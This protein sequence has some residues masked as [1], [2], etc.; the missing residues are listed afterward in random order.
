M[1]KLYKFLFPVALMLNAQVAQAADNLLLTGAEVTNDSSH[2]L[3]LGTSVPL[4]RSNL[5]KGYVVH[6]WAD[7]QTYAYEAGATEIEAS[8]NSLSAAIGYHDSG[9][10][11]WW[12][13][14]LGVIRSDTRLSP[15]DPGNDSAGSDTNLKFQL[16]GEKRTSEKFK[17]IGNLEYVFGRNAYWVRGRFVTKNDDNSY[18]GPELIYQGDPH[19]SAWQLGWILNEMT[20]G[21]SWRWGVKAGVRFDENDT[22][23]Y[24]GI[25]LSTSY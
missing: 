2:Y 9:E 10:D 5:G 19:Y 20:L 16:E 15:D 22:S 1:R 6:L 18:D 14:R 4:P 13:T 7:Y 21:D 23:A 24:A 12:N 11:Y 25:E 8:I 17:M 3:Y